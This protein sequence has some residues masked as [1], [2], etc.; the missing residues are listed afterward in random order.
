MHLRYIMACRLVTLS[1][2]AAQIFR[3][4]E[5]LVSLL[6]DI[7][8]IFLLLITINA[9]IDTFWCHGLYLSNVLL[10]FVFVFVFFYVAKVC[11]SLWWMA[12]RQNLE[13]SGL[14]I[15]RRH[16]KILLNKLCDS[17]ESRPSGQSLV[18]YRFEENIKR[19]MRHIAEW[20]LL[21]QF[22]PNSPN[23]PS[24]FFWQNAL[25]LKQSWT[26]FEQYK[27]TGDLCSPY[28]K[29]NKKFVRSEVI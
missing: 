4:F 19:H 18:Q 17:K 16:S 13:A 26:I 1:V 23:H 2:D 27:S 7:F 8:S 5:S 25:S 22:P 24:Q 29:T 21:P 9:K 10:E 15:C 6:Q 3:R 12:S 14:C 11:I 20:R 28:V